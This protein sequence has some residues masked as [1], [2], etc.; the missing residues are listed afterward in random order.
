[1]GTR[2]LSSVLFGATYIFGVATLMWINTAT[3]CLGD[4]KFGG[5]CGGF[6]LYFPLWTLFYSPLVATALVLTWSGKLR[7]LP[8][9]RATLVCAYLVLILSALE[10]SFVNDL[11][12]PVLMIE[13][14]I[15]SMVFFFLRS[16]ALSLSG[17]NA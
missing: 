16:L 2:W 5:G 8:R 11:Q 14:V 15:L 12:W 7:R 4:P 10:L 6:D 13:W 1:M 9:I 3:L 17:D